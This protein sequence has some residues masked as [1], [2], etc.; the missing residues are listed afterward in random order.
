MKRL[1]IENLE[2]CYKKG[3]SLRELYIMEKT[4]L[5]A[6]EQLRN[7]EFEFDIHYGYCRLEFISVTVEK[8]IADKQVNSILNYNYKFIHLPF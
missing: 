1:K 7:F 2:E 6:K 3:Y 5:K 4:I 8:L